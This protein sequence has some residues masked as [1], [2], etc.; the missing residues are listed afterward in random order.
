MTSRSRL[1]LALAAYLPL[2]CFRRADLPHLVT[3]RGLIPAS[4]EA[5]VSDTLSLRILEM[6]VRT[7][8][9]VSL[10]LSGFAEYWASVRGAVGFDFARDL[11][12]VSFDF[13]GRLFE[14]SLV[15]PLGGFLCVRFRCVTLSDLHAEP[16]SCSAGSR[17]PEGP[18]VV[19]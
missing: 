1:S 3:V 17:L 6:T 12:A 4:R 15:A 8:S 14:G 7:C 10:N 13:G 19:Q 5:W 2:V 9:Q 11:V 16:Y 18:A